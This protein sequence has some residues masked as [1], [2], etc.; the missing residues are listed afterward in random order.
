VIT[1][2][3]PQAHDPTNEPYYP[4]PFGEGMELYRRYR[5]LAK[6]EPKT[7]FLGRLATYAYLDMWMAVAQVMVKLK[8]VLGGE[9]SM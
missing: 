5:E 7:L 3:Y 9:S 8:P 6:A 4:M 2:E 1:K